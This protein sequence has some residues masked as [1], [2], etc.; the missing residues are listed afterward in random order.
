MIRRN[1]IAVI[2]GL[3][4]AIIGALGAAAFGNH[5]GAQLQNH[6]TAVIVSLAVSFG[7]GIISGAFGAML[8][9]C[10]WRYE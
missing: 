2:L 10:L 5:I 1:I 6:D 4:L 3:S 8:A 7:G 9:A